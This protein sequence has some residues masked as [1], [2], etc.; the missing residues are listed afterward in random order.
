ME[1]VSPGLGK[2]QRCTPFPGSLLSPKASFSNGPG[3]GSFVTVSFTNL[4]FQ[5]KLQPHPRMCFQSTE[6]SSVFLQTS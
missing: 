3:C 1:E 5:L 4:C 2:N 6:S